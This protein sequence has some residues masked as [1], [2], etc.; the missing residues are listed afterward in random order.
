MGKGPEWGVRRKCPQGPLAVLGFD[1]RCFP[2]QER[3]RVL[4][5]VSQSGA[6]LRP[7]WTSC[8]PALG[9]W[10]PSVAVFYWMKGTVLEY[11]YY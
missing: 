5:E 6:G 11:Y 10:L 3:S 2:G 4:S 8:L 7:I 9:V 1:N